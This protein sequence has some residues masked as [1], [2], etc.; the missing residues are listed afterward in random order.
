MINSLKKNRLVRAIY[1]WVDSVIRASLVRISPRLLHRY[2]YRSAFKRKLNLSPP[3]LISEKLIWLMQNYKNEL[4]AKCTDKYEVRNF[5]EE[6][7]GAHVLNDCYFVYDHEDD[8]DFDVLPNQFALKCTHGCGCNII[9]SDKS[10]L[11]KEEALSKLRKWM[12]K[13]YSLSMGEYHYKMIKPRIICEKF[14]GTETHDFATDYKIWC[15][16]GEPRFLQ[17]NTE[18]GSG[19]TQTFRALDWKLLEYSSNYYPQVVDQKKP[20]SL[21][22]M[23]NYARTLSKGFPFVR[24]DFYDFDGRVV[25]GELTFTPAGGIP[26]FLNHKAEVELGKM[27]LLETN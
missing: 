24:V 10:K 19:L 26:I 1:C 21:E 25:F 16:N 7:V 20:K 27:L 23:I 22:E 11:N 6:R 13:D 4:L 12:K 8:I 2:I 3:K 9:V 14:I 5:V 15:F 17:V 18:R